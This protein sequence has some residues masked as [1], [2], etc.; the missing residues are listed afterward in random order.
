MARA[1]LPISQTFASLRLVNYRLWFA[2]ALVSNVGAWIQRVGQDWLVLRE[3]TD[4]SGLAAGVVTALQFT[5]FLFLSPWAGLLADRLPRR[6][7]LLATQAGQGGL[8]IGLGALVWS[9]HCQLWHVFGFAFLLGCVTA[10]DAPVRQVF[11]AEMVP[12]ELLPNA[13]GLNSASFNSSR[14]IGPALAGLLIES[15]GTS[16]AFFLNAITY[17]ATIGALALMRRSELQPVAS[18]PREKGQLRAGL[19]YVRGRPDLLLIFAVIFIVSM[20]GLNSQLTIALMAT[21]VFHKEAGQFGLLSSIFA[22]GALLGALNAARRTRPRLRL[23][24]ATT[25]GF[26][27]ASAA[28]A[29]MPTYWTFGLAGIFVGFATLTLITAA[30]ATIQIT[31]PPELRG[32]VIA[33]YM[34]VFQGATP[35]GSPVIGWIGQAWG[36]RWAIAVGGGAAL[37]AAGAALLWTRRHWRFTVQRGFPPHIVVVPCESGPR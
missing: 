12:S 4:N 35:I 24:L 29:A 13:V 27:L 19:A 6:R 14:L 15:F 31:T 25:V 20:L 2:G 21:T 33:L 5:P 34:L 30:N 16:W 10:F 3:L 17:A 9:G 11:V 22:I 1:A 26:G 18:A 28:S 32:R 8:A 37:L 7:L 23:I 36:A